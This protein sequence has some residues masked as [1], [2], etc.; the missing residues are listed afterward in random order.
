MG[1]DD[2][3][4]LIWGSFQNPASLS[5]N[6][7]SFFFVYKVFDML[8]DGVRNPDVIINYQEIWVKNPDL[9]IIID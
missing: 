3:I 6:Q 8:R 4:A 5:N 9:R 7:P 2:I 1:T